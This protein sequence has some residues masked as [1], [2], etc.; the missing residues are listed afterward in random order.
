MRIVGVCKRRVAALASC[1]VLDGLHQHGGSGE[2]AFFEEPLQSGI[3]A[4]VPIMA[5]G[6]GRD[7]D[8][9]G[10]A[11]MFAYPAAQIGP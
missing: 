3:D 5:G 11:I 7:S 8:N 9:A 10:G 6:I 2:H 1:C 4:V